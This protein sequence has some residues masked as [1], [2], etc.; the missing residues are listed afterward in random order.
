MTGLALP[1]VGLAG[2]GL[3]GFELAGT[4]MGWQEV[5]STT[6]WSGGFTIASVVNSL[7]IKLANFTLQLTGTFGNYIL[8]KIN[9]IFNFW[10][11]V[12]IHEG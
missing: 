5:G 12:E 7:N 8:E 6:A 11:A 2:F 4:A 9:L 10:N 1:E 3:V